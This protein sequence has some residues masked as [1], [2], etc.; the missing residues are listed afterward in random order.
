VR[1]GDA[2][3]SPVIVPGGA[4]SLTPGISRARLLS[5][6]EG[7]TRVQTS[8]SEIHRHPLRP[9]GFQEPLFPGR[10]HKKE[11]AEHLARSAWLEKGS[12][13]GDGS[14]AAAKRRLRRAHVLARGDGGVYLVARCGHR[15]IKRRIA[16]VAERWREVGSWWEPGR[17]VDRFVFRL[18]LASGA[19][20]D[21]AFYAS[22]S[23]WRLVGVVD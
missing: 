17:A 8:V 1:D 15:I 11:I 3:S 16:R 22:S 23:E 9:P 6:G 18:L 20:V 7:G 19:V 2:L 21:V 10:E 4:G 14:G 13:A 12:A 5:D